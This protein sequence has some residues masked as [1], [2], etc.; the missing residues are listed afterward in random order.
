MPD[1][2]DPRCARSRAG[3]SLDPAL[4]RQALRRSRADDRRRPAPADEGRAAESAAMPISSPRSA[5][6]GN[7][8]AGRNPAGRC[9]RSAWSRRS[10]PRS[11]PPKA[12]PR[13][14]R[15]SI[16]GDIASACSFIPDKDH[17][18]LIGAIAAQGAEVDPV[19]PYVYDARPPTPIS[20]PRSRRWRKARSTRSR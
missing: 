17:G 19:L 7:S 20:S 13:C 12:L 14:C 8:P 6:R 9:A 2:H 10:R 3:R 5:R 1:V 11:R 16:S 18:A 4:H 15:A